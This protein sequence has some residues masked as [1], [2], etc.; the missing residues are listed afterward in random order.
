MTDKWTNEDADRYHKQLA[1]DFIIHFGPDLTRVLSF[2]SSSVVR[3]QL[4]FDPDAMRVRF[5]VVLTDDDGCEA[6][7]SLHNFVLDIFNDRDGVKAL[8]SQLLQRKP[9]AIEKRLVACGLK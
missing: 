2:R 5:V 4:E 6:E 3:Q 9:D 1:D 7:F 8:I